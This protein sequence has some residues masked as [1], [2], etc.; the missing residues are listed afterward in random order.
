LIGAIESS[1]EPACCSVFDA[2]GP[3]GLGSC[4]VTDVTAA[5][6]LST[7]VGCGLGP[8]LVA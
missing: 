5:T 4:E 3:T 8:G 7:S 6:T 2:A 1:V